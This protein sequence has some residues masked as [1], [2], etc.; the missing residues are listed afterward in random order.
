V[1]AETV[2][3][4][5][6]LVIDFSLMIDEIYYSV[7]IYHLTF[8]LRARLYGWVVGSSWLKDRLEFCIVVLVMLDFIF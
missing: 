8:V 6:N 4:L 2:A 7:N 3:R 1:V 5:V